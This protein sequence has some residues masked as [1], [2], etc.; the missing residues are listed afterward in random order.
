MVVLN[1]ALFQLVRLAVG[2]SAVANSGLAFGISLPALAILVVS[3][4]FLVVMLLW[5]FLHH[6]RTVVWA[7]ALGLI[8]GGGA[9]NLFE[10]LI[11]GSVADYIQFGGISQFN[12]ADIAIIMGI[13]MALY[14][15][16][17]YEQT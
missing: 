2:E 3:S 10:R 4:L 6:R 7:V 15:L 17:R 8:V 13:V 16:V 9:S 12:L 1:I 14:E 11:G 5:F